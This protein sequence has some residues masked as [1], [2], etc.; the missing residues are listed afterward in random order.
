[1]SESRD[2]SAVE[3]PASSGGELG[4]FTSA[5]RRQKWVF[6]VVAVVIAVAV[7]LM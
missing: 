4:D 1:M 5:L 7:T 3:L 6:L 2:L